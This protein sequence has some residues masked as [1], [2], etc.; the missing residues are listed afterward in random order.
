MTEQSLMIEEPLRPMAMHPKKFALWLFIVTVIMIFAA[1]TS[2]YIVRKADGNWLEFPLPTILWI[3]SG[4][5]LLSSAT[6]QWAY[7]SAKKNEFGNLKLALIITSFLGIAFL[8]GQ[9]EAWKDL[10]DMKV[11]FGG[12][13][14]NPSGSFLYVITGVHA[15][16]LISGII[17]LLVCLFSSFN[18]KIHSK[19]MVQLE[20]CATYWHFLDFLWIYLFSFL[21]LNN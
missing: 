18:F 9:F 21:L 2:A 5:M 17:F 4:I 19:N 1:L 14:S 15:V 11:F 13:T 16:H 6:I 7:F 20:M 8:V 10:V 3:N 12:S